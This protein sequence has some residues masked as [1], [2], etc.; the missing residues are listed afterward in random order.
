[1]SVR[2]LGI[3]LGARRVGLA[4]SDPSA[5]IATPHSVLARSGDRRAEHQRIR[6]FVAD[7]GVERVV[8][9]LPLSMDGSMGVAAK[10]AVRE[11][12]ALADVLDVPVETYD[13]RLTTVTAGRILTENRVPGRS[14]RGVVDKVAAAVML[15]AWLDGQSP[16][17]PVEGGQQDEE[18]RS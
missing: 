9:G 11:A 1:M 8:V 15:Q 5:T 6:E 18:C 3:D 13:E 10:Q 16:R 17:H 7:H 14:R 2:V 12:R 4:L